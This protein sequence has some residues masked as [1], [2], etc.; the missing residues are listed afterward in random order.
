MDG[1]CFGP[2]GVLA[3]MKIIQTKDIKHPNVILA[4]PEV[5]SHSKQKK[6]TSNN[7]NPTLT[8]T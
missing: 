1:W 5:D 3:Q 6:P 7:S 4:N 2:N 8:K